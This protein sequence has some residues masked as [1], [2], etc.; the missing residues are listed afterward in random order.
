MAGVAGAAEHRADAGLGR[1]ADLLG[2]L[3][4]PSTR[5]PAT[6]R[7]GSVFWKGVGVLALL[8]GAA[9]FIG[10]LA[11]SRDPLQ[12]LA[13]LRAQAAQAPEAGT[14][15]QRVGSVE[16]LDQSPEN[17]HP[18]GDARFL[19]RLVHLVQEMERFTFADPAVARRLADFQL[20]QADVTANTT[21]TR[22]CSSASGCSARRA[23][24]SS[25]R[26]PGTPGPAGGRL[27]GTGDLRQGARRG[28]GPVMGTG[29]GKA[30]QN[31][32]NRPPLRGALQ[33]TGHARRPRLDVSAAPTR[34]RRQPRSPV[35]ALFAN[36]CRA[37]G[38]AVSPR[39]ATRSPSRPR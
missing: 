28:P 12:P 37:R 13:I 25:T 21:P 9:L 2:D 39:K 19:C 20:L 31:R 17:R 23:S 22:R 18:P 32:Y 29:F 6:R 5:C 14:K 8:A 26:R 15:F 10:A 34:R 1:A 33:G 38:D 11:G 36:P 30:S 4:P 7:A 3:P 35:H 27:P 24:S 16:A